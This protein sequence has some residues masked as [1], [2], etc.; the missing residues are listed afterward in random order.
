VI[1]K[2]IIATILKEIVTTEGSQSSNGKKAEL[3][4]SLAADI[5]SKAKAKGLTPE[6]LYAKAVRDKTTGRTTPKGEIDPGM[7]LDIFPIYSRY[8]EECEKN[9]ALDFDDLLTYGVKLLKAKPDCIDCRHIL[10]DEFQDTNTTQFQLMTL[11]A[12]RH[13]NISVVGDPDQSSESVNT[14]SLGI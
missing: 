12:T 4:D 13:S 6:Q 7:A 14:Y 9:N 1:R 3:K 2:K 10:V 8:V 11:F 5:I